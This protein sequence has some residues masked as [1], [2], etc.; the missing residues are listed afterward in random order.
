VISA[1]RWQG[2]GEDV[3]GELAQHLGSRMRLVGWRGAHCGGL[4]MVRKTVV[5]NFGSVSS[6]GR[7]GSSLYA[8]LNRRMTEHVSRR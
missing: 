8:E 5:E 7:R 1:S 3:A 6:R 4:A 2:G